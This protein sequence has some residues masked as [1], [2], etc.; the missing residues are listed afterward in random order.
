MT[1]SPKYCNILILG[2][3]N[4]Y[5]KSE[6]TMR[7]LSNIFN[8]PKSNISRWCNKHYHNPN[9]INKS[10]TS[11][12]ININIIKFIKNSIAQNPF[13]TLLELK[14]KILKK[15]KIDMSISAMSKYM[16]IAKLSKKKISVRNIFSSEQQLKKRQKEFKKILK[17]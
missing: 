15:F 4:M 9:F 11:C 1:Y 10:Q 6:Y 7:E 14:I 12:Q 3:I 5:N 2:L 8:I 16:K 17:I 13:Q